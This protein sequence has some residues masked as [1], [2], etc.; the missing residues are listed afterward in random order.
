[1]LPAEWPS[2]LTR[3]DRQSQWLQASPDQ[4]GLPEL[5]RLY[6]VPAVS[7]AVRQ[8]GAEPWSQAYGEQ[9]SPRSIF[10]ACSI[11]KH[12]AAFGTVRLVDHGVLDLDE[13]IEAYLTS[14]RLPATD[15]WRPVV[16][17]RQ[18]LAHTAGLSYNW[19]RGF[20]PGEAVPEMVDVLAGRLP[21]TSPPVRATMLPGSAFR[22][23]GSHYAVLQQLLED[24]TRTGFAEL[25]QSLV[26]APLGMDDSSY[27]QDFPHRHGEVAAGH[28]VNGTQLRGGWRVQPEL[29]GAGMWTTP[30]DLTRVGVEMAQAI[31]G[32][33]EL[34][35][36]E[37]ANEMITPQVPG[38]IGLGTFVRDDRFGHTG[39]NAG[40]GCWLF[41]W[42]ATGTTMAV[43]TNNEMADE[44]RRAVL[45]AAEHQY[46]QTPQVTSTGVAGTYDVHDGYSITIT[47]DLVL[48]A[49]GQPP[50]TLRVQPDGRLRAVGLDC[51]LTVVDQVL[52]LRQQD[53]V[54]TAKRR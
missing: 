40:Y 10:Q 28:H 20:G 5:M 47:D 8:D 33:S 30:S 49:P 51:E 36:R 25:M 14:W 6:D 45:A 37:L 34:L 35:S 27:D 29:A 24:V 48:H 18:L 3:L 12:V 53:L 46:G 44:V 23:S 21:A 7:L 54:L 13:N 11:S 39:G 9:V 52:E 15:G 16:T 43:M 50:I 17:I 1:M 26:L 31:A 42:P 19:F 22:Y 38:G 4:V 32:R 41:T 2:V